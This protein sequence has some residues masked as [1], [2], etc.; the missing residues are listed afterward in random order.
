LGDQPYP[1]GEIGFNY[2][3]ALT[4]FYLNLRGN[5]TT[6]P[7]VFYFD[8]FELYRE[9]WPENTE[10]VYSL[11]GVYVPPTNAL[12]V[13]WQRHKDENTVAHEVRYAFENIHQIGWKAAIPAPDGVV[14]P[15]GWQGYNGMEWTTQAIDVSGVNQIFIAIKPQDATL[16]RQISIPTT[17]S[18]SG[19]DRDGDS[20]TDQAEVFFYDTDPLKADTDCDEILDGDEIN[21]GSDPRDPASPGPQIGVVINSIAPDSIQASST[22]IDIT[23]TGCYFGTGA[24]VTFKNG[25][26][27]TPQASDVVV[28]ESNEKITARVTIK[29][30]GPPRDR[31]WD[32]NV[33]NPD[34]SSGVLV[35][36]FTVVKPSK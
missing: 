24:D 2:F 17:L 10:Q 5:L 21:Q 11:N 19:L 35:G 14:I 34:G 33:T 18:N 6:Y 23:I 31:M 8:A 15:L 30:G 28:Q 36:G 7:A 20:L 9:A 12:V 3:D 16:F 29:N 4:R 32:L 13:G 1:T 22:S 25:N 27:P 26:G